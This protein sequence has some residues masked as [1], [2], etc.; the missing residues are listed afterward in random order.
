MTAALACFERIQA[1][2]DSLSDPL[3]AELSAV[4][5][6]LRSHV[7]WAGARDD[8]IA[9][10]QADAI[11]RAAETIVELEETR[12]RLENERQRAESAVLEAR[13]LSA[14]GDILEQSLN[15]I[16]IF[17]DQSL[18]FV[19]VNRGARENIGYSIDELRQMTLLDLCPQYDSDAFAELTAPLIAGVEESIEFSAMHMR[20]DGTFYPTQVHLEMSMLDDSPVFVAIVLDITEQTRLMRQLHELAYNDPL[21]R[22]ANRTSI[23]RRIQQ[24]IDRDGEDPFA[25]LFLDFDRFKLIND[26]LGHDFGDSLLQSIADRLRVGLG[27]TVSYIPARLG[28]D[29]FVVLLDRLA[30]P[31]ESMEVAERILELFSKRHHIGSH[32]VYCTVSIGVVTS[33]HEYESATDMVRDADLAMYE[34][35]KA[36]KGCCVI[37]GEAMRDKARR[38]LRIEGE[39]REAVLRREFTMFFQPIVSLETQELA[40]VEALIRWRHPQQGLVGPG[41]FIPVAE[42]TGLIVPIGE[43]AIEESLRQLIA[44]RHRLGDKAPPCVHVNVSRKQLLTPSFVTSVSD[45]L[46]RFHVSPECLHLEVTES[47]I[48]HDPRMAVSVLDQLKRLGVKIDMDDFGTG[49]SSLSCLHE[50]PIDILKIDRSFISTPTKIYEFSA[51]LH[52]VLTLAANLGMQVVSEGIEDAE[53]LATL[54]ALGCRYGQGYFF[55]PPL[56]SSDLIEYIELQHQSHGRSTGSQAMSN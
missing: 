10:A 32:S 51:L 16:Y 53:Q 34:A 50:F 29:E 8:R 30:D 22:L 43:W 26:S 21:T 37:F 11:V 54:Q 27:S 13:R 41:E 55:S 4:L 14:F 19:H 40:G 23:L 1:H 39:L 6:E 24:A 38:R 42:E 12:N 47:M 48:M 45:L 28:G 15:E 35:K 7:D 20:K 49:Y 52:S 25:L 56:S 44:W 2:I 5:S 31:S 46:D 33:E 36:G 18:R 3:G 17:D 9:K